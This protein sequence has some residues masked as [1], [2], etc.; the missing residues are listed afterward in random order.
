LIVESFVANN[1]DWNI[2]HTLPH[3][4]TQL[5]FEKRNNFVPQWFRI[6]SVHYHGSKTRETNAAVT[7]IQVDKVFVIWF[8]AMAART[9][10]VRF[11]RMSRAHFFR[12]KKGMLD[13]RYRTILIG[14]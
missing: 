7:I 4:E 9:P 11:D 12:I 2:F 6:F 5:F 1:H 10:P 8:K 13:E 14:R 3:G